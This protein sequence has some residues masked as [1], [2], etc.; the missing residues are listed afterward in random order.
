LYRIHLK[1]RGENFS[2][3][4]QGHLVDAWS[5]RRLKSGGAGFFCTNGERA[6]IAWV[7]IT[8]NVDTTGRFCAFVTSM[9]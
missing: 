7:R 6:R 1:A 5:E 9:L 3:Y 2:L 8:H 4:I